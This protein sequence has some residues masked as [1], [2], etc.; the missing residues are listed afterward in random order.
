MFIATLL[1][2]LYQYVPLL[3]TDVSTDIK[4][5][6]HVKQTVS[7]YLSEDD[8]IETKGNSDKNG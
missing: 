2:S 7:E 6:G 3:R 4:S 8:V 5:A 1:L